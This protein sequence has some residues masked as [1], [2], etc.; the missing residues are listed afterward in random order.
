[1][2]THTPERRFLVAV[3]VF[4][5]LYRHSNFIILMQCNPVYIQALDINNTKTRAVCGSHFL[6]GFF[7]ICFSFVVR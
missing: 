6:F 4:M 1:M 7:F 2:E 5:S 3:H